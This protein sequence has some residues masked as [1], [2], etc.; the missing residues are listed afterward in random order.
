MMRNNI[1]GAAPEGVV[2]Y[3]NGS[4]KVVMA[5]DAAGGATVDH[6]STASGT[7]GAGIWLQLVRT[8]TNAYTGEFATSASGPWTTVASIAT[9]GAVG[10]QDVGI[11]ATSGSAGSPTETDFK[12]F[13]V[14]G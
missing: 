14:T 13:S 5:W 4:G 2:L 10:I 11:F 3:L 9:S 6:S 7:P 8:G 1:A 12:G